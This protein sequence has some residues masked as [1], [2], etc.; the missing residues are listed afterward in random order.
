MSNRRPK[1]F[2]EA[3]KIRENALVNLDEI[4]ETAYALNLE[5]LYAEAKMN[6][7]SV[8]IGV[9]IPTWA[10]KSACLWKLFHLLHRKELEKFRS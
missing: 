7:P 5:A 9:K 8:D 2:H 3:Q 4:L 1:W 10:M 6:V